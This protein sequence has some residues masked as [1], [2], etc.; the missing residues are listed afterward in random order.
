ML[1][2]PL[3][4][5]VLPPPPVSSVLLTD[6]EIRSLITPP[7]PV[8]LYFTSSNR[9]RRKDV[10][11]DKRS[12]PLGSSSPA[13][14]IERERH[15]FDNISLTSET[16]IKSDIRTNKMYSSLQRPS[17]AAAR[18]AR[19]RRPSDSSLQTEVDGASST[20]YHE[21]EQRYSVNPEVTTAIDSFI[22]SER[23]YISDINSLLNNHVDNLTYW[24]CLNVD[25]VNNLRSSLLR[26]LHFHQRSCSDL[27][28]YVTQVVSI[29]ERD[30]IPPDYYAIVNFMCETLLGNNAG[31][32]LYIN[33]CGTRA[34]V[35]RC[36]SQ[37]NDDEIAKY[38]KFLEHCNPNDDPTNSF[39][40]G[41][42]MPIQRLPDY[43]ALIAEVK[44]RG[45][46]RKGVLADKIEKCIDLLQNINQTIEQKL[47][48]YQEFIPM[49]QANRKLE[50]LIGPI[51][52]L[53]FYGNVEEARGRDV[54][55]YVPEGDSNIF[56]LVYKKGVALLQRIKVK[57]KHSFNKLMSP[58]PSNASHK[59]E[60]ILKKFY[61]VSCL[62]VRDLPR[63]HVFEITDTINNQR[64]VL[65]CKDIPRK[66]ELIQHVADIILDYDKFLSSSLQ[67]KDQL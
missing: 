37:M 46:L 26:I 41:I 24:G 22:R 48:M 52:E 36:I 40:A 45:G 17:T 14:Y 10:D 66:A 60:Y 34:Q 12:S 39:D 28:L 49:Y 58:L 55:N 18:R 11:I 38:D 61:P 63:S 33:Y 67:A 7:V 44:L 8:E 50:V 20:R 59:S 21:P 15:R 56:L 57:K 9:K 13:S 31:Y 16:S 6:D 42:A 3:N 51:E 47:G 53:L 5:W 62:Q 30:S 25:V 32:R 43:P 27:E 35:V 2:S 23:R 65:A 29:S 1:R 54:E 19:N 4:G 64:L